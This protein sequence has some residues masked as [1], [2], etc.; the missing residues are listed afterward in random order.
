MKRLK[1]EGGK[2][3]GGE[4]HLGNFWK[5]KKEDTVMNK[6]GEAEDEAKGSC[7]NLPTIS[8]C[9]TQSKKSK[10]GRLRATSQD[11]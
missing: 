2:W 4:K 8:D 10:Q 7:E 5:G 9:Y 11:K 6:V 1:K 3:R